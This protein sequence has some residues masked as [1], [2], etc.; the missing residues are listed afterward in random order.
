MSSALQADSLQPEPPGQPSGLIS[1]LQQSDAVIFVYILVL[2]VNI[3]VSSFIFT[4]CSHIGHYRMLSRV[5]CAIQ[6]V[7]VSYLFYI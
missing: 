3:Y 7:L 5:P 2:Y 6:S 1:A 4:F